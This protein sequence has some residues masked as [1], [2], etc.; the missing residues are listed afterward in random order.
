MEWRIDA[1]MSLKAKLMM[2]VLAGGDRSRLNLQMK[3]KKWQMKWENRK[4][5][6][7][8]KWW[9]EM[10]RLKRR[11]WWNR[12]IFSF[13]LRKNV[14]TDYFE[15]SLFAGGQHEQLRE[16]RTKLQRGKIIARREEKI[17]ELYLEK[18]NRTIPLAMR[19]KMP[20]IETIKPMTTN[21]FDGKFSMRISCSLVQ[22][23]SSPSSRVDVK[24]ESLEWIPL[25]F[26]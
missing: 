4:L 11:W 26:W 17:I 23:G 16:I 12:L 10:T 21:T 3:K 19:P 22:N 9:N 20:M 7:A 2:N 25:K 15:R 13:L 24:L 18:M 6:L 8:M 14:L 1:N 5:K